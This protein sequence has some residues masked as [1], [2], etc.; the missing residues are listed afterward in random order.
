MIYETNKSKFRIVKRTFD[1]GEIEYISQYL[2]K[3]SKNTSWLDL[4]IPQK[5]LEDAELIV[6]KLVEITNAKE[7][8]EFKDEVI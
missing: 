8:N 4:L 6:N 5:N 1:N 2:N 7:R 3:E